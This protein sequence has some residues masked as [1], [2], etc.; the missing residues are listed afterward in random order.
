MQLGIFADV[1]PETNPFIFREGCKRKPLNISVTPHQLWTKVRHNIGFVLC[2]VATNTEMQC[3]SVL[4]R[5][6]G[7]GEVL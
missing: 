4:G 1:P 6:A 3:Y 7:D 5:E 2:K